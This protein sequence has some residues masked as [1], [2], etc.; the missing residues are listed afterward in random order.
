MCRYH[1][2]GIL[3]E[4]HAHVTFAGKLHHPPLLPPQST[5]SLPATE[6]LER[7]DRAIAILPVLADDGGALSKKIPTKTPL[8]VGLFNYGYSIWS[9]PS[10]YSPPPFAYT[11]IIHV[12][13]K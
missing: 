11:Y 12:P 9:L 13:T 10:D 1:I 3:K 8:S 4:T 7:V 5:Y 2:E 6:R